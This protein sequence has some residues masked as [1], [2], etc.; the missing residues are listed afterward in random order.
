MADVVRDPLSTEDWSAV[1]AVSK[2]TCWTASAEG[3]LP[4]CFD[5]C[6]SSAMLALIML[7]LRS[8]LC[9][10]NAAGS[11]RSRL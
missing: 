4:L 8:W 10:E 1:L 9:I 3:D 7:L 2:W 6:P 11:I 5:L